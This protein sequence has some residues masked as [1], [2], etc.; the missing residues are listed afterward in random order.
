MTLY[1]S[2]QRVTM[3]TWGGGGGGVRSVVRGRQPFP[4]DARLRLMV[5]VL[6]CC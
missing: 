4:Q 1:K 3:A 6:T 5:T 2:A